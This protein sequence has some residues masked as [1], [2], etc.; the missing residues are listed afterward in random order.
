MTQH[1]NETHNSESNPFTVLGD[2]LQ[3]AAESAGDARTDATASAK[4]AAAKKKQ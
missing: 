3:A 2:A 4:A 1:T